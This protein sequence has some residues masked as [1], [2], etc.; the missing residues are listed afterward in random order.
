MKRASA[1]ARHRGRPRSF[2]AERALDRAL[3]VFWRQG[4]EGTSMT[5]LTKAMGI[6]PPSLYATFGNKETLFEKVLDRY[7][8]GPGGYVKESLLAPTAAEF[9][10]QLLSASADFFTD[11]SHACGCLAINAGLAW[12]PESK[13]VHKQLARRHVAREKLFEDRLRQALREGDLPKDSDPRDLAR[14]LSVVFQGLA[15]QAS[16]GATR[17]DLQKVVDMV[18]SGWPPSSQRVL[19]HPLY[20][21]QTRNQQR[22]RARSIRYPVQ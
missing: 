1:S 6:N 7:I 18:L 2:D 12:N 3:Q 4:Y 21:N 5:D 17:R 14:Y 19:A 22:T 8:E 13:E 9:V 11:P 16:A 20:E 15:V 10:R